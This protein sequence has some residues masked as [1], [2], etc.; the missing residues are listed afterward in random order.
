[1]LFLLKIA[2]TPL[3]VAGVSLASRWWGPTIGGVLMGL[4][5]FTGPTLVLLVQERGLDFGADACVGIELGVVCV[6]VYILT[7]GLVAKRARWPLSLASA[8]ATF[9]ASVWTT[10]DPR[11]LA[12]LTSVHP[13]PLV[14]ASGAG[15]AS[16]AIAYLLLPRPSTAPLP[17]PLPWWD[18][19][20][21]MI[22]TGVLVAVLLLTADALGPRLSGILSTYPVIVTVVGTFTHYSRGR[23]ALWRMLRGVTASLFSFV[24]FFLVVGASLTRLGLWTAYVL[25]SV[26]ALTMTGGLVALS[27]GR[28]PG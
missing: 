3:L 25:A 21:R 27:R 20:S 13:S 6:A 2:I 19:P 12:W 26:V 4:P 8:T 17:K 1:M 10:Q 23:E 11:F 16:L 22:A 28:R 18:I 7:Y 15:L 24:V 14:A 5:W 9:G